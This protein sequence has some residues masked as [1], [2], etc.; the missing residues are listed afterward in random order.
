MVTRERNMV[1]RVAAIAV[2][3]GVLVFLRALSCDFVN[4]DD[5]H[6]IYENPAI[7]ILDWQFVREAFTSSYMGWWMPLTW[8]SFAVDYHFWGNNPLGYHLV[9]VLLHAVNTGLVVVLADQL[10]RGRVGQRSY[11]VVLLLAAL[12]WG[13]HPLR[14]ES[15]A[16]ATERKDVLNGLFSL[17]ALICYLI[18]A[19]RRADG[20]GAV[21]GRP[22]Y[23]ASLLFFVLSLMAKPVSVVMPA[24]FLVL[25]WYPLG[26]L[27]RGAVARVLRE[28]VPFF[29]VSA[30]LV[31][32]TLTFAS[33]ESILIPLRDHP[34]S[35]RLLVAGYALV[36]YGRMSFWPA[37]LTHYY[38][39]NPE[40]PPSYY[41][42]AVLSV[43][44]MASCFAARKRYPWLGAGL[45]LFLL[46]LLPVLGLLQ[47]GDQSHADRF[48]YLPS[49]LPG[50]VV[51][52]LVVRGLERLGEKLPRQAMTL[53]WSAVAAVTLCYGAATIMQIGVW[54]NSETLWSRLIT[55]RP[56]GRAYFFRGEHFLQSGQYDRAA[57]DFAISARMAAEAGN[58]ESFNLHAL[59]GDALLKGGR[60]AEA[61]EAFTIAIRLRPYANY[62]YYRGLALQGLGRQAEAEADFLAAGHDHSPIVWRKIQQDEVSPH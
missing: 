47:N 34:L 14:V 6:Y 4:Y 49:I 1:A 5:P 48:I 30:L 55:L 62:Y 36:E 7:R 18:R 46:P 2:L 23:L 11:P 26:R 12:I 41:L 50:I 33:G 15:V 17:L 27:Q 16:W 21:T 53:A 22:W 43:L 25:D 61:L 54:R 20:E 31:V 3:I 39:L 57:A 24:M 19:G 35:S 9:N 28:K 56:V 45:L 37:G 51:A 10:L 42:H 29:L 52:A 58:P 8:I 44:I 60:H 59:R 32:I 13:I 38:P 40:L